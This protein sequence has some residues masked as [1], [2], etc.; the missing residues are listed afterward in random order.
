M[1]VGIN[2][3][4]AD[5]KTKNDTRPAL[6][7]TYMFTDV[8]GVEVMASTAY[9]HD[10][11]LRYDIDATDPDMSEAGS[12][13]VFE[14]KQQPLAL[15]LVTYPLGNRATRVHPYLGAGVIYTRV[16]LKLHNDTVNLFRD[17][18]EEDI[19]AD[20]LTGTA[21]AQRREE[22]ERDLGEL[23]EDVSDLL[24]KDNWGGY[25]MTGADINLTDKLSL[26]AQ[27]RYHY[28]AS[29]Y[30]YLNYMLGLGYKF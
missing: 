28:A 17:A 13:N 12:L 1:P 9:K 24:R 26:N 23:N 8:V 3:A 6:N 7:F 19:Q 11:R 30:K 20:G 25:V 15:G 16:S 21:A 18:L 4:D 10:V 27:V 5:L 29:D 2:N 22:F 14:G